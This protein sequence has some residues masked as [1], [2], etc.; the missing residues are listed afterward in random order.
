[1]K[2]RTKL[3]MSSIS[4]YLRFFSLPILFKMVAGVIMMGA[5]SEGSR[6]GRC[7]STYFCKLL[8]FAVGL[9]MHLVSTRISAC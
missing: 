6:L 3:T 5:Y 8:N 9:D 7:F 2:F 1:M 4:G